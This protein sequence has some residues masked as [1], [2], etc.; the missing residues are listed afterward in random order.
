[1]A[2]NVGRYASIL[3]LTG[4]F[5]LGKCVMI[6][7]SVAI[8]IAQE[9]IVGK[10]EVQDENLVTVTL[11]GD[12]YI[13]TFERDNPPGVRGPDYDAKVTIDAESGDVLEILGG[14]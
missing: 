3:L 13:V 9:A 2:F 5:S 10:V 7:E 14:S 8:E 1:M 11:E 12:R 6:T 4:M